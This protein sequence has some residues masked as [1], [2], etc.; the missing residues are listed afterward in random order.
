MRKAIPID[1]VAP[2][3]FAP[4]LEEVTITFNPR[5]H[6]DANWVQVDIKDRDGVSMHRKRWKTRAC[7]VATLAPFGSPTR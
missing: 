5:Y 2:L 4:S 7:A 6:G 1:S 3:R